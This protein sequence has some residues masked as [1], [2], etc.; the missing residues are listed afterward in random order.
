MI[1]FYSRDSI[2]V[3]AELDCSSCAPVFSKSGHKAQK[4]QHIE[5]NSPWNKLNVSSQYNVTSLQCYLSLEKREASKKNSDSQKICEGIEIKY[6]RSYH[7]CFRD[8]GKI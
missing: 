6:G 8:I 4:Q 5:T 2:T 7:D 1:V 3:F